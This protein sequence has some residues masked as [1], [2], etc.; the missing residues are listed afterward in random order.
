MVGFTG[1]GVVMGWYAGLIVMGATIIT[2]VSAADLPPKT[3]E[4]ERVVTDAELNLSIYVHTA[5]R[6]DRYLGGDVTQF[7]I[8]AKMS[9]TWKRPAR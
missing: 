9:R 7:T 3:G 6:I 1:R 4:L 5:D 2:I 8:S